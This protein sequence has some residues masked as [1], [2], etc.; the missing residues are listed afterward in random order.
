MGKPKTDI[1]VTQGVFDLYDEYCHGKISRRVFFEK[2]K[3]FAIGGVSV[4]ALAHAVL[5][6]YATAQQIPADDSRIAS[7][8]LTYSSPNGAGE[9][10]GLFVKPAAMDA[11]RGGVVVIHENR[12]LNP[13]I[14]DVAR[15]VAVAGY[16]AFAPDGLYPLG[17]YPGND[18][19]GRTLQSQRDRGE[20]LED[21]V[22]AAEFLQSHADC[23]G[24][25]ACSG[26]CYGGGVANMLAVRNP[27]LA[28]AVPFYGGWPTAEEAAQVKAPLLIHLA[29]LDERI[30]AGWPA[31]EEALK[32]NDVDYEAHIYEGANHGFH[33][34]TTPRFD[35]DAAK[36]AWDRTLAF[37]AKHIG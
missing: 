36:L 32:A 15:R 12:G 10:S 35:P 3:A 4:A 26:F 18:D 2:L 8:R 20:M 6:K 22:A 21:F 11:P 37:F 23:D 1:E 14:E 31:Y 29:G 19:D 28:A 7:E 13:H 16:V 5:P 27:T 34:D 24:R 33:N 17:G 30:N 9:M 25:V